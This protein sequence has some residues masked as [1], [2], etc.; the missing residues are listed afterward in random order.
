MMHFKFFVTFMPQ[1]LIAQIN[2]QNIR[3]RGN[4]INKG[5][6][7]RWSYLRGDH[8]P[9]VVSRQDFILYSHRI[10]RSTIAQVTQLLGVYH[11][12]T[13]RAISFGTI[14]YTWFK[15]QFRIQRK[16]Q[17]H[18]FSVCRWFFINILLGQIGVLIVV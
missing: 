12:C 6:Y 15:F 14:T 7:R 17:K 18:S 16:F 11:L 10:Q 13:C 2:N 3:R 8:F 9:K 5:V 1:L 4:L